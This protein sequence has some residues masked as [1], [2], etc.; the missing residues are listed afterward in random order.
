MTFKKFPRIKS[1]LHSPLTTMQKI[2]DWRNDTV[3]KLKEIESQLNDILG[4][5]LMKQAERLLGKHVRDRWEGQ[6]S[7]T[8]ELLE[9]FK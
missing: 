8:K 7:V 1:V 9:A 6:L 3:E 2:E 4:S 5:E